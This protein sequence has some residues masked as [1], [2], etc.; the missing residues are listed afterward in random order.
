MRS[1]LAIALILLATQAVA[2]EPERL[3]RNAQ[4]DLCPDLTGYEI[5]VHQHRLMSEMR[6]HCGVHN[7]VACGLIDREN[8][9]CD[10]HIT[11]TAYRE[12]LTHLANE[13]RGWEGSRLPDAYD[14]PWTPKEGL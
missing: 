1:A 5:R 9:V 2:D 3:C 14:M 11:T 13:C 7:M 10:L 4:R 12:T 6:E 8:G